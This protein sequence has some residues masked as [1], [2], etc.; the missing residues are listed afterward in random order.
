MDA[1]QQKIA[2]ARAKLAAKYK[3]S[4]T[5][6]G[7]RGTARRKHKRV[8]KS[9]A[10]DQKFRALIKKLGAEQIPDIAEVNMFTTDD[11][12]MRFMNPDGILSA[13]TSSP[14]IHP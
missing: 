2:Q 3:G 1:Q 13:L 12:V 9:G 14:L 7:G 6:T 5:Q 4:S 11:K 8:V 10:T